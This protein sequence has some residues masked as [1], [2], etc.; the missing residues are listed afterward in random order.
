M[1]GYIY[2]TTN[3]INNKIYIGQH[4]SSKFL[5]DK[6]LGSGIL[7]KE[8]INKYGKENFIIDKID[9]A[10]SEEELNKKEI[11]WIDF[12]NSRNSNIGYNIAS[13]GA[14]G[15]SG[16][17][18][19]MLNK[20]QSNHQKQV[21]SDYMKNRYI[22]EETRKKMSISAKARTANRKTIN[23]KHWVYNEKHKLPINKEDIDY[24]LSI[25]Y[26]LGSPHS[27]YV[28][29]KI[30]LKYKNGTYINKDNVIKFIPLKDLPYYQ[31]I[32][33]VLGKGNYSEVAG[34]NI[35]KAK[36]NAI[37]ITDGIKT[38][39]IQPDLWGDYKIKGFYKCSLYRFNKIIEEY[40]ET[41]DELREH[42]KILQN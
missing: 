42:L 33:F 30:K 36:K 4:K 27:D 5:F 17:H 29:E 18:L 8:A 16:Y 26:K 3:L 19:G 10:D 13:G 1:Y 6:Y 32:G 35:S 40:K 9:E 23:N 11:Y 34:K 28:R 22:S 21:V 14:F 15:D 31:S 12:Y 24:Y 25:G 37:A 39:F 7:I 38:K 20:I 41:P 2:K